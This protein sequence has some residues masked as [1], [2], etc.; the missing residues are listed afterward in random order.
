ML[1]ARSSLIVLATAGVACSGAEFSVARDATGG[2]AGSGGTSSGGSGGTISGGSGGTTSGGSGA[3][4]SGGSGGTTSGGSGGT[5][6]GGSGGA[7]SGGSG[8]TTSGGSAGTTSGGSGGA[9]GVALPTC[10]TLYGSVTGTLQVCVTDAAQCV[11]AVDTD[12][13]DGDPGQ[14]CSTLCVAGGGECLKSYD[15]GAGA[16][17]I[18]MADERLCS[19]ATM[20]E[21]ICICSRG[22]G[23]GPPCAAGTKCQSGGCI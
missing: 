19:D 5:S 22:C 10:S 13:N 21:G 4:I 3:T 9:G 7:T 20:S 16:C 23:T 8:G 15:N 12:P 14:P 6:S 18:D 2:A 1:G 17:V 11:L